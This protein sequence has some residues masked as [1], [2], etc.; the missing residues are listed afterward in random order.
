MTKNSYAWQWL[1][2]VGGVLGWYALGG[3][4]AQY[5][6]LFAVPVVFLLAS[7]IFAAYMDSR[8][9]PMCARCWLR[10]AISAHDFCIECRP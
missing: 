5:H 8:A 3:C 2:Q 6:W 7:L 10:P 4:S 9:G 1:S